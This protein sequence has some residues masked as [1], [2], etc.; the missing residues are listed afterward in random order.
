ME[1]EYEFSNIHIF[2]INKYIFKQICNQ[3]KDSNKSKIILL[4]VKYLEK[5]ALE[6]FFLVILKTTKL[7]Y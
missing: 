7:N 6:R 2:Y 5:V 4:Q 1:I 3:N